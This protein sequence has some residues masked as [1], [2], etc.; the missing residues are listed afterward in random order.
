MFKSSLGFTVYGDLGG[1]RAAALK[2]PLLVSWYE[3]SLRD[4]LGNT[5]ITFTDLNSDGTITAS[6]ILQQNHYYPFGGNIEGL[7][8]AGTPNKYQYNGKEWNADFGLEWNDYGARMYDPWVGRWWSVDPMS[9]KYNRWSVYTSFGDNPIRNIDPDGKKFINFDAQGNYSNTSKDKWWHNFLYGSVGRVLDDNGK[10]MEKFRFADPKADVKAIQSG[11]ITSLV[12]VTDKDIELMVARSGGFD[13]ENKTANRDFGDRYSYILQEGR[14]MGR[15]DFSYSQIPRVYL[16]ASLDPIAIHSS[17]IFLSNG[18]AHNQMNFGNFLY[19][20][21][22]QA[23]GFSLFELKAGAHYNSVMNSPTNGY[24]PQLDSP[25]D[26]FSI[27]EGFNWGKQYGY[28]K[29]E[30]RV[31]LGPLPSGG[32]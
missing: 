19:G 23:Q 2:P 17:L 21:S 29:K 1:M 12:F 4:H 16:D 6:E 20:T 11:E 13:H 7:T 8:S 22:G 30:F 25:D 5:R 14:G 26:Q 15:M 28:D 27:K 3:Y 18:V 32:N 24:A 10:S 31:E 9:E